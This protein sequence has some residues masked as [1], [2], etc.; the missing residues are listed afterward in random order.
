M[1]LSKKSG[2]AESDPAVAADELM[3]FGDLAAGTAED[4]AGGGGIGGLH[5][6]GRYVELQNRG[7]VDPE[8]E[9]LVAPDGGSATAVDDGAFFVVATDTTIW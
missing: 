4:R 6:V 5:F 2:A 3:S 7:S 1:S 9:V 8:P